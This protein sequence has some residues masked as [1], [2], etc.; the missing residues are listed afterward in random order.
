MELA[1]SIP[2]ADKVRGNE[3][4]LVLK[5]VARGRVPDS[6]VNRRKQGFSAPID[7]WLSGPLGQEVRELLL[8][9]RARAR[10]YFGPAYVEELVNRAL[11][12]K[13]DVWRVWSLVTFEMW[14]RIFA[15]GEGMENHS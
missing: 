14:C 6:I 4:K 11:G 15:D 3:S 1:A 2:A 9:E 10:D 8:G 7:S 5:K 13:K 12:R